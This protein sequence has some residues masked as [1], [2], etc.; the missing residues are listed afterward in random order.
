LECRP[1]SKILSRTAFAE[2][3]LAG[4]AFGNVPFEFFAPKGLERV[5]ASIQCFAFGGTC[6][7]AAQ[8]TPLYAFHFNPGVV[9]HVIKQFYLTSI[10]QKVTKLPKVGSA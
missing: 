8:I 2:Y 4:C 3:H 9:F 1:A 10:T 6:P 7:F 5:T